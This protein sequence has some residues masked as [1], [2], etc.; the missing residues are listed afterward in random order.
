MCHDDDGS[1]GVV[2]KPTGTALTSIMVVLF[3]AAPLAVEAQQAGQ[4]VHTVAS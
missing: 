2:M 1:G 3:L 4:A